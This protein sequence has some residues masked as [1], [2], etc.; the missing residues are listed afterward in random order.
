[1]MFEGEAL[2][3][4]FYS[5]KIIKVCDALLLLAVLLSSGLQKLTIAFLSWNNRA[6]Q[7]L[8]VGLKLTPSA[9]YNQ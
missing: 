1:M 4:Y 6:N 5:N 2:L 9:K 3:K 8:S 7:P